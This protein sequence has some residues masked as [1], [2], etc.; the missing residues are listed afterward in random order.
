MYR[1]G[2]GYEQNFKIQITVYAQEYLT[3]LPHKL[4]CPPK[5]KNSSFL[6]L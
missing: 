2:F 6:H 5:S 4:N 3:D 1:E